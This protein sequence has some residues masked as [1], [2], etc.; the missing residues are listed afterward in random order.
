MIRDKHMHAMQ[1]M[2]EDFKKRLLKVFVPLIPILFPDIRQ[3]VKKKIP[4]F[5]EANFHPVSGLTFT[6]S[7]AKAYVT[8]LQE[9]E[10]RD[11]VDILYFTYILTLFHFAWIASLIGEAGHIA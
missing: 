8:M 4:G 3:Y 7:Q 5:V 2:E 10:V 1:K 9:R 6:L 11:T